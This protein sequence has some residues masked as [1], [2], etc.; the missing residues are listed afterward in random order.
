MAKK[1][2][3]PTEAL[4]DMTTRELRQYISDKATEAQKRLDTIKE[5]DRTRAFNDLADPITKGSTNKV[6]RSTSYMTKV[7]LVEYAYALRDFNNFDTS[8]KY[9]KDSEYQQNK[10]RYEKFINNR[11]ENEGRSKEYWSRYLNKDGSV[12]K[13]GYEKYKKFI[14]FMNSTK[15]LRH[16]FEY[17]TVVKRGE[18]ALSSKGIKWMEKAINDAYAAVMLEKEK[19]D[20]EGRNFVLTPS[21]FNKKL[22]AI[23]ETART[24][25]TQSK[26][27]KTKNARSEKVNI[28]KPKKGKKS[29]S[30]I[31]TKSVGK[32]K[33][34]GKV[35][36]TTR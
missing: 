7:E 13:R 2:Y 10:G 1:P 34:S 14:Q 25:K 27:K 32:M 29:K 24:K 17:T 5:K 35:H 11:I 26:P 28:P 23:I 20:E 22:D 6:R 16:E 9:A 31:K 19:A 21:E 3:K 36:R 33:E 4:Q 12:S 15:D 30:N 8:S 18:E